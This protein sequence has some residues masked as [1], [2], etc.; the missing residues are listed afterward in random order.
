LRLLDVL[1]DESLAFLQSKH[2]RPILEL[3]HAELTRADIGA[4]Q[5]P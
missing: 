1:D 5:G 4:D 2:E 3:E